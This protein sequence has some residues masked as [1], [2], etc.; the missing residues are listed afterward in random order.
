MSHDP[1]S[2]LPSTGR[3]VRLV[4][5][6]EKVPRTSPRHASDPMEG[7]PRKEEKKVLIQSVPSFRSCLRVPSTPP[8]SFGSSDPDAKGNDRRKMKAEGVGN[9]ARKD[10]FLR[11]QIVSVEEIG[12]SALLLSLGEK[13]STTVVSKRG[14]IRFG[15]GEIER[16][17]SVSIRKRI[18]RIDPVELDANLSKFEIK[19][20]E[21][22]A[23]VRTLFSG[24]VPRPSS[25]WD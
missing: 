20:N 10:D 3:I 21:P 2:V 5:R 15:T 11:L 7:S 1:K 14:R 12:R 16:D 6:K 19:R 25:S 4:K 9:D 24:Y 17:R 23:S 18:V 13:G 22:S 8:P